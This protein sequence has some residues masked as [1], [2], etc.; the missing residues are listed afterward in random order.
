ML[1]NSS[2]PPRSRRESVLEVTAE[3]Q[4]QATAITPDEPSDTLN[5]N[6]PRSPAKSD[7]AREDCSGG[8]I[9]EVIEDE[10][11]GCSQRYPLSPS[12]EQGA[13]DFRTSLSLSPTSKEDRYKANPN[14]WPGE[15][16]PS[17][18]EPLPSHLDPE[19]IH[20]LTVKG[21]LSIPS[22]ALLN[23]I[24]EGYV[25]YIHPFMPVLDLPKFLN[26]TRGPNAQ[27]GKVSLLLFQA[28]MFAGSAYA[29]IKPLRMTGFLTRKAARKALFKRVR[30]GDSSAGKIQ[31]MDSA[32]T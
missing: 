3:P 28:V 12:W 15:T 9:L 8:G 22:P 24:L 5:R 14:F 6:L 7:Y 11:Q 10:P 19:D 18:I 29:D 26:V 30:V 25:Q 2:K 27:G 16:L 23:S 31:T 17:Y 1:E 13:I 21:A 32:D 4:I 20:Y